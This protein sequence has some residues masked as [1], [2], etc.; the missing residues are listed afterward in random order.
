MEKE[1]GRT[2]IQLLRW[3]YHSMAEYLKIWKSQSPWW[4]LKTQEEEEKF[5]RE[6]KLQ[7]LTIQKTN[8]RTRKFRQNVLPVPWQVRTYHGRVHYA[9]SIDQVSNTK[10]EQAFRE[11]E[12]VQQ[13][14]GQ[15]FRAETS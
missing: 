4:F 2:G 13:I 7:P 12:K 1:N 3:S 8:T 14:I 6:G 5:P 11:K 15:Y 10:E 9:Q